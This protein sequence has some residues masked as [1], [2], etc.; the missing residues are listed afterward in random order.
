MIAHTSTA[1]RAVRA[2]RGFTLIEV[3]VALVIVAFGMAALLEALSTSAQNVSQLRERTLAEWVALNQVA[4][5]RL[6]LA[7]PPL[8]TTLGVVKDFGNNNW[9]WR[10]TVR[11]VPGIQ[12]P[13]LFEIIVQVRHATSATALGAPAHTATDAHGAGEASSGTGWLARVVGF[14]G[15]D[16]AASSGLLPDWAGGHFTTTTGPGGNPGT[17]RT[18]PGLPHNTA[19]AGSSAG[20]K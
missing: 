14:R 16:I 3:L 12:I 8:G 4:T 7:L 15:N 20:Q 1:A 19:G 6:R 5:V 10:Q 11:P 18:N 17:R 2:A 9:Q 13:G